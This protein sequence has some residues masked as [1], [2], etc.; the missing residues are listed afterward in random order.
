MDEV[1]N[2]TPN[3]RIS[4][5]TAP[6]MV[7][8]RS[9]P[10]AGEPFWTR[11]IVGVSSSVWAGQIVAWVTAPPVRTVQDVNEPNPPAPR[12]VLLNAKTKASTRLMLKF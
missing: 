1:G 4:A 10:L 3:V 9:C 12:L 2:A 8:T 6:V 7:L 5:P 11:N